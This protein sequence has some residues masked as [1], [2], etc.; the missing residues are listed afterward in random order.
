M[1]YATF[2]PQLC[3]PLI[4]LPLVRD[5]GSL[6]EYLWHLH[7]CII[8]AIV[9]SGLWPSACVF[10]YR[11]F[12]PL[13]PHVLTEQV[14]RQLMDLHG[15][16]FH[17]LRLSEMQGLISFPSFHAAGALLVTWALRRCRW[18]LWGVVALINVGQIDATVMLGLHYA[19]DLV[20]TAMLLG[21]SLWTYRRW[22][23]RFLVRPADDG[24]RD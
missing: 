6:W 24:R 23:S 2:V 4:V 18:W 3:V 22:G 12:E 15:G 7:V 5:R 19:V 1:T 16:R 14:T 20:G 17:E 21:L 13:V 8:V 9:C 10:A 11:R